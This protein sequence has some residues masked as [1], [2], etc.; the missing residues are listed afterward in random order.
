MANDCEVDVQLH[1]DV[2]STSVVAGASL[3]IDGFI[4]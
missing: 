2:A 1:F 4:M 3:H